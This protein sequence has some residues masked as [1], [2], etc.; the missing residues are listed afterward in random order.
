MTKLIVRP[1]RVGAAR[2]VAHDGRRPPDRRMTLSPKT[3]RVLLTAHVAASV[4]LLGD[5]A[6]FLA[7]ALRGTTADDP[8]TAQSSWE[9]L[10][11][12]SAVF[13]IPMS[14]TALLTGVML[15]LGTKWGVV[16]YPW[17]T[18]KLLVI[19]SVILVGALV[20]GPGVEALRDGDSGAE[21][22][23]VVGAAYDVLALTLATGLSVF[24]PGRARAGRRL[25][26]TGWPKP[27]GQRVR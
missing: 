5:S 7:V 20:L 25:S 4:G 11:M 16:R 21:T 18:A 13:G 1:A 27:R 3:R 22:R 26:R 23:V 10:Q 12:F 24:K 14:M 19:L 6:G 15:G 2:G 9:V 8:A 17:V